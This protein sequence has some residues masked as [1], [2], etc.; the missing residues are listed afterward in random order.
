[1]KYFGTDGIRGI[2]NKS[3]NKNLIIKVANAIV[4]FFSDKTK[5][6][7]LVGN[8]SR[9]SSDYILSILETVL[10]KN[11]IE[12]QNVGVC[13]SPCLAYLTKKYNYPLSLMLSASHNP[14]EYNGIKFFNSQGEKVDDKFEQNFELFMDMRPLKCKN[15]Y[16][17]SISVEHLKEDYINYL[18]SL[19]KTNLPC[20]IDC[21]NGGASE[22][23]KRV[24][25]KTKIIGAYPNGENINF[26]SGCTHIENLRLMCIKNRLVGF[27]LDGDAD[28]LIVVDEFGNIIDG[29]KILYILSSFYLKSNDTLVGTIYSNEGLKKS[30]NKKH[31]KFYR[32][33]VGDKQVYRAMKENKTILGGENSGHIILKTFSNTGDGILLSIILSNILSSTNLSFSS[34]LSD[35]HTHYQ[36]LENIENNKPFKM[37]ENL[38]LIIRKYE[39]NGARIIIRPSGTEPILRVMVETKNEKKSKEI[40]NKL[41]QYIKSN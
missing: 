40:L 4:R 37:N 13:S 9:I 20:I 7:L 21:A 22:I 23:V 15:I 11:G 2:A 16:R 27:A 39:E 12:V 3:L 10:L 32:S 18:K 36:I 29:D 35:Y 24:F 28:R 1:M 17:K 33:P 5:K 19:K 30:L 8:D 41:L 6:V 14:S 31:I 34:L 38:K 26:N 25:S